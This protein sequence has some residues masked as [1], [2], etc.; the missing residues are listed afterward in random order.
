MHQALHLVAIGH[1]EEFPFVLAY[2]H[3]VEL[4]DG[5]DFVV[6]AFEEVVDF[7]NG[8]PIVQHCVEINLLAEV[9][10]KLA[11]TTVFSLKVAR[12]RHLKC[13]QRKVGQSVADV[14][15]GEVFF[16]CLIGLR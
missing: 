4:S 13:E 9:V 5:R 7:L 2:A 3:V 16:H 15:G 1:I 12:I 14:V 8:V 6:F 10:V 11:I